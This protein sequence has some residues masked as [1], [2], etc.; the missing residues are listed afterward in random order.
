MSDQWVKSKLDKVEEKIDTVHDKLTSIDI[1]L[2]KQAIDLEHHIYRTTLA[3]ENIEVLRSE[4]KPIQTHVTQVHTVFKI[5]GILATV[6]GIV[7]GILEVVKFF[8]P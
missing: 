8:N 6:V 5:I 1:T 4:L 2:A 3:E 7:V